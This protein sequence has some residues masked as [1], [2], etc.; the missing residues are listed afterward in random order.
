MLEHF[1][2]S[3]ARGQARV[4]SLR[5][6]PHGDLL[7]SFSGELFHSRYA[8]I[9]A[10]RHIRWAEHFIHVSTT[11]RILVPRWDS[12]ALESFRCH[13]SRCRCSYGHTEPDNQLTGARLFLQHL[14]TSGIISGPLVDPAD[15]P[16][17]LVAFR[18]WM[19]EQRGTHDRTLDNYDKAIRE[20]LKSVGDDPRRFAAQSI[21][22]CFL[23]YCAGRGPVPIKHGAT[24]L[25]MF[26]RFLIADSQCP[27]GLE[28]AIPLLPH[29]R[30]ASLPRYLQTEEVERIVA[31]CD[32]ATS[33][34]KRDRAILLLLARLGLRAGDIVQLRLSDIDWKAACIQVCG[35]GGRHTRL[36]LTQELGDALID[37]L[38]HGRPPSDD[39]RV[40]LCSCAPFRAFTSYSAVSATVARAMRRAKVIRPGRG[41]AHLLRHSVATSLLRH[42]ASLQDI[43]TVLRHRSIQTTQIYAKVDFTAL[44]Q[45]AQ[46]WPEVRSC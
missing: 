11:N 38:Q 5:N 36:P 34:G 44:R 1:F 32:L 40:F 12:R 27:P 43:A 6:G 3:S 19:H 29:W 13:L 46:P 35:K 25:R 8:N 18:R 41:A 42:G 33:V 26:L 10:R 37:Y 9:T 16:A 14:R 45:I 24:A 4:R 23:K 7:D 31:S 17:L 21:R 2:D 15:E 30:L 22:Q 20:L 28:A 39:D